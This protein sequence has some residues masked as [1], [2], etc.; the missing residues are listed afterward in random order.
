VYTCSQCCAWLSCIGQRGE[1]GAAR[2]GAPSSWH[3]VTTE[4][5][6]LYACI[7]VMHTVCVANA[8]SK[9][10]HMAVRH[11]TSPSPRFAASAP[12]SP[13]AHRAATCPTVVVAATKKYNTSTAIRAQNAHWL[14]G[15]SSPREWLSSNHQQ[16]GYRQTVQGLVS[17]AAIASFAAHLYSDRHQ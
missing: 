6:A 9:G 12:L 8:I 10:A 16:L 11:N 3:L 7:T 4:V 2:D 17:W 14:C 1:V 15:S 5:H 13:A